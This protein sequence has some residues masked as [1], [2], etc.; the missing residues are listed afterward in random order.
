MHADGFPQRDCGAGARHPTVGNASRVCRVHVNTDRVS[1]G[2]CVY[3]G[4]D[5]TQRFTE[6]NVCTAVQDAHHL[7]VSFDGHS[8]DGSLSGDFEVFDP[9]PGG[10][11]AP[12]HRKSFLKFGMQVVEYSHASVL[13]SVSLGRLTP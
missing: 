1:P 2:A 7:S 5:A 4:R 11:F 6:N 3:R 8:G 12:T 10:Q 13:P 9:H